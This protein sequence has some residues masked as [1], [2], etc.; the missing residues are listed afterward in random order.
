MIS[1]MPPATLTD[2][3]K[4][5][6]VMIVSTEGTDSGVVTA[7]TLLGGVEPILA[8]TPKGGAPMTLSP[9]SLGGEGGEA[10]AGDTGVNR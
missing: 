3:E 7:I 2:F 8:A 4:G 1:H 6:A 10:G 5:D 9:W